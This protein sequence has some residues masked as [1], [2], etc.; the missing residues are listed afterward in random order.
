M[1]TCDHIFGA[2]CIET[3]FDNASTC[4]LCRQ[5]F[6]P[7]HPEE[8]SQELKEMPGLVEEALGVLQKMRDRY[9]QGRDAVDKISNSLAGFADMVGRDCE[10]RNARKSERGLFERRR[11]Q[12]RV[13][14]TLAEHARQDGTVDG[15]VPPP[16]EPAT[17]PSSD[18]TP[19]T[20]SISTPSAPLQLP[21][22]IS[23]REF[24]TLQA[25]AVLAHDFTLD[26]ASVTRTGQVDPGSD[27]FRVMDTAQDGY[28]RRA[29][30][31]SG[32]AS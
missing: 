2:S 11:H 8:I 12:M 3:W 23:M 24:I 27:F 26:L 1:P 32:A 9:P 7:T 30:T 6:F 31:A 18:I 17:A 5:D 28:K 21:D 19:P 15:Q 13:R 4:P 25:E 22:P 20:P 29:A 10:E 16:D 14:G